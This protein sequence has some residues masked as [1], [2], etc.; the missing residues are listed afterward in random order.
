MNVSAMIF[1]ESLVGDDSKNSLT[2]RETLAVK[3][4]ESPQVLGVTKFNA[5]FQSK[6]QG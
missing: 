6:L 5:D 1:R 2:L 3:G 4:I